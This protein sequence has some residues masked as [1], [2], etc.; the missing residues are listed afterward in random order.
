[1]MLFTPLYS[2]AVAWN[3]SF[4]SGFLWH[5]LVLLYSVVQIFNF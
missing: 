1:M 3:K 2:V 4:W 5:M